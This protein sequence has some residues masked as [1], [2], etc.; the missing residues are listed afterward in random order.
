MSNFEK[1]KEALQGGGTSYGP[2]HTVDSLMSEYNNKGQFPFDGI[3]LSDSEYS[4]EDSYGATVSVDL[5]RIVY[6]PGFNI[7]VKFTGHYSSYSGTE[8][9]ELFDEVK[10][11]TKTET[12]YKTV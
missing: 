2:L 4:E 11:E 6:F 10:P 5:T 8:W 12:V 3:I 7:Y 9:H 1:F